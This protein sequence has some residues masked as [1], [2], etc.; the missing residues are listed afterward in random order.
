MCNSTDLVTWSK[1]KTLI[2]SDN[3]SYAVD[4]LNTP[5]I[6]RPQLVKVGRHYRL[7]FG[8][9]HLILPDSKQK[10]SRYLTYA[11]SDTIDGLYKCNQDK[12]LLQPSG[13]DEYCNL[14]VGSFRLL[15][16][17]DGFVAFNCPATWNAKRNR[18]ETN[19][20]LMYS[21]DGL[22][23]KREKKPILT[24]AEQ[25]WANRYIMG[26]DVHYKTQEDC[27]YCYFCANGDNK[28]YIRKEAI[29]LLI[30]NLPAL[31]AAPINLT[32]QAN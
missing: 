30:G 28:K 22:T 11:E 19:L 18:S 2:T 9:S 7:Y 29:G 21:E 5:R 4:Y 20:F 14:G 17:K 13:D 16:V 24:P 3:V 10:V 26:C 25:G 31:K 27:W 32:Y 1:P 12:P 15:A 6:S 23:W 8:A